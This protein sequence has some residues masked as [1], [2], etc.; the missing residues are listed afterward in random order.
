MPQ[1]LAALRERVALSE[2]ELRRFDNARK[3]SRRFK[4]IALKQANALF[5]R[6]ATS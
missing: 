5:K 4:P 6:P 2:D 1:L 3:G